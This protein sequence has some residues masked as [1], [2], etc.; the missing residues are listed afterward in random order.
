MI[1][2]LLHSYR[3]WKLHKD[4]SRCIKRR[5]ALREGGWVRRRR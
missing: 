1:H 5:R 4:I 3:I 2:N